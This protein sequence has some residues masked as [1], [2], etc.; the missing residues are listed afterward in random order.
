[1]LVSNVD[2]AATIA[3]LGGGDL[4]AAMP[5][6]SLLPLL[7]GEPLP[8]TRPH[9]GCLSEFGHRLMLETERYKIIFN[10]ESH[11]ILGLFDLLND[12]D[13]NNN[14]LKS[15]AGRNLTDALRWRLGDAL[16]P[17]RATANG[18]I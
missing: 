15:M 4:P 7:A 3:T 2:V 11:R 16:M 6:R 12:P 17:L 10:T 1:W 9:T 14:L 5:G 18:R 13:E 8:E